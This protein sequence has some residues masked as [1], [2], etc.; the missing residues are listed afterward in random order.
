MTPFPEND[1][2]ET[3]KN[4]DPSP[5]RY[6]M[7][8]MNRSNGRILQHL[9]IE[10]F[11]LVRFGVSKRTATVCGRERERKGP[12]MGRGGRGLVLLRGWESSGSTAVTVGNIEESRPAKNRPCGRF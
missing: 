12:D 6:P 8:G 11:T 4:S 3:R 1:P 10:R 5:P 9:E 2:A 7:P